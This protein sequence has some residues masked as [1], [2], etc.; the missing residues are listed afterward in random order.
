MEDLLDTTNTEQKR[1]VAIG[2]ITVFLR[3]ADFKLVQVED[4]EL[5]LKS[6]QKDIH[7]CELKNL[8]MHLIRVNKVLDK[9]FSISFRD[10]LEIGGWNQDTKESLT[11]SVV[12]LD[13]L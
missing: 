1:S 2:R 12:A 9:T 5:K 4:I 8:D 13:P 7:C 6:I 10:Y 11:D 3:K